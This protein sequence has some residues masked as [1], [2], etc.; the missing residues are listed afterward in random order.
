MET[1]KKKAL[2]IDRDGTIVVE[3]EA[4]EQVD[5]YEKLQFLP[6]VITSLAFIARTLD[7]ELVM[8]TNQDGLG[9]PA[10]PVESFTG[11]HELMLRTLEGEG[12]KSTP[13]L[14][15]TTSPPASQASPCW[16]STP[17]ATTTWP[18]AT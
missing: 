13:H 17:A 18:G 15:P 11:P 6:G 8:V 10:F 2:F 9:T 14:K 7:Y 1:N 5:S 3:P 16:A 12:V 4:D